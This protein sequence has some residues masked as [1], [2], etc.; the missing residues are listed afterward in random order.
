MKHI[1]IL[2]N[3]SAG[4]SDHSRE[5]LQTQL[6]NV[7][8]ECS[9][10]STKKTQQDEFISD[11]ADIMAV[12]GGDGTVRKLADQMLNRKVINRRL[13]IALLPC[14]T[15][16]NIGRTL[17]IEG[18]EEEIVSR[19]A[20]ENIQPFDVAE[21]KGLK[22]TNFIMEALGFGVFP[23]LIKKMKSLKSKP[24]DAEQELELALKILHDI[25][26]G[27]K[28]RNCELI[29][30]G[31]DLSG[32]YLMV[33]IMN[34]QSV[35][36]NLNIAPLADTHDG[37]LDVVA[38]PLDQREALA[39]Y[40]KNRLEKGKDEVFF[41]NAIKAS[42]V[43]IKWKGKLLHADDMLLEQKKQAPISLW[44]RRGALDFLV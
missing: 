2:H 35:G 22:E 23:K 17:N 1:R 12:V 28:G 43:K 41:G 21:V 27:Y 37:K 31:K 16:N 33:E 42:N 40:V 5:I 24:E 13:P 11:R 30:D 15:A 10:Y 36:P 7:G 14:G 38:V 9:Y 32:Q 44:A 8:F 4:T 39:N 6:Q 34:I 20:A 18:T 19:W 25:V 3:P 29:V 26:L